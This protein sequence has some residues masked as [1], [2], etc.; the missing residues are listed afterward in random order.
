MASLC[1][2]VGGVVLGCGLPWRPIYASLMHRVNPF[3]NEK[4]LLSLGGL[5]G[6]H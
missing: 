2:G 6:P 3:G 4:G 1:G 5:N